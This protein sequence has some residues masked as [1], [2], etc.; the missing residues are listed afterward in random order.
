MLGRW[1]KAEHKEWLDRNPQKKPLISSNRKSVYHHYGSGDSCDQTG[2][3]RT[4][5]VKFRCIDHPS[6]SAVT[7]YLLEP[8]TC[9]LYSTSRHL[10]V[11][12][13]IFCVAFF[14]GE[15]TLSVE[16]ALF[17]PL[18]RTADEY[19]LFDTSQ[20]VKTSKSRPKLKKSG[21]SANDE[22]GD[23]IILADDDG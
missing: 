5:E 4:V 15:Y 12:L 23:V 2:A 1:D 14:S 3:P 13:T 10:T 8:K 6:P 18:I 11:L 22:G 20:Y 19:G 16:S 7:L 9:E 17:C 21:Q